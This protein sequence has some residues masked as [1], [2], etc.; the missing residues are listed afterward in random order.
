MQFEPI[1]ARSS[2]EILVHVCLGKLDV[3]ILY[4]NNIAEW[5]QDSIMRKLK[6]RLVTL[7]FAKPFCFLAVYIRDVHYWSRSVFLR[8]VPENEAAG[9]LDFLL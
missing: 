6:G 2:C 7:F 8:G 4:E 5:P 1:D 9:C 3:V